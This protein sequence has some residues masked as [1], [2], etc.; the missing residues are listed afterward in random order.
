MK[1]LLMLPVILISCASVSK[2]LNGGIKGQ[3]FWVAGN[4]M[5]GPGADRTPEYGVQRELY[6]YELTTTRQA[7]QENGFFKD[8]S[9]TLVTTVS[10]KKDGTFTVSLPPGKYSVFVKE[11]KGLY[12]NLFDQNNAI[13][14][15][16]VIG[17]DFTW[18][19]ITIDYMAAY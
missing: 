1:Y 14:P 18:L 12:A 2:M 19:A 9:T 16:E 17:Q 3:V 11:P 5:P 7:T 15:V 6:I 13:N 8:I 4:Q 10:T